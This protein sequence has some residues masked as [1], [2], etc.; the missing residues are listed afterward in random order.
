MANCGEKDTNSSQFFITLEET[1]WLDD[2]HVVFGAVIKGFKI[3][4]KIA[5]NYG[6]MDGTVTEKVEILSC[7]E[8]KTLYARG[9]Q[10][11]EKNHEE[12]TTPLHFFTSHFIPE[13]QSAWIALNLR[14]K[15]VM[16]IVVYVDGYKMMDEDKKEGEDNIDY[17]LDELLDG[18]VPSLKH[19]A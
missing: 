15:E 6:K 4:D 17:Q 8:T 19:G 13:A 3:I 11:I 18:I 7:G 16:N 12:Y 1:P 14:K 5:S 9:Q 10:K 2:F